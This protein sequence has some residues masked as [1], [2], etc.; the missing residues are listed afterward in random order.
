MFDEI[1][2]LPVHPLAVHAAV[3]L[4]PL[5]ALLA[6]LFVIAKTRAWARLPFPLV[7]V[8][9]ALA[10]YVSKLS[11]QNFRVALYVNGDHEVDERVAAHASAA[12]LLFIMMLVFAALAVVA[13]VLERRTDPF[14][15]PVAVVVSVLLVVGA[16]VVAFQ[17]LRVGELGAKA[18]WNPTGDVRFTSSGGELMS[19]VTSR[20]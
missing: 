17:T 10:V 2:G 14:E 9:A 4:V 15:G 16:G 6:V 13:F 12:N 18:V 3:V 5:A 11:G 8:G 1:R 7:A 20:R 19:D